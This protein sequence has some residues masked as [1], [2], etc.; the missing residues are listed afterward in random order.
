MKL[1]I[2]LFLVFVIPA[3]G[4][5]QGSYTDEINKYQDELNE[6]F[7]D[8]LKSPLPEED[9]EHFTGLEFFPA[10]PEYKVEAILKLTPDTK[11][12][13]MPM[14][15]ERVVWYK[16]FG[17]AS[18]ELKGKKLKLAIYQNQALSENE[19]YKDYLFLPFKDLTNGEETYGGGR[20]IDM[21]IPE[22]DTIIIDFN[23]SYN[24]YCAYN[25]KYSCPIPPDENHLKVEIRAGVMDYKH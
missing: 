22:E 14:S 1:V 11:P 17:E 16:K 15:K 6:M 4:I 2:V 23:K 12:F 25:Y 18:F 10:D 5:A 3:C 7:A 8:S 21:R 9:L 24:P 19:E 13:K 20:Y